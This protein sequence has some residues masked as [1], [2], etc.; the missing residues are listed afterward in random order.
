MEKTVWGGV[1]MSIPKIIHYCW[2]GGKE[3]PDSAIKCIKSWKK[4][5]PDY[6]IRRW[7]EHNF[8]ISTNEFCNQAYQNKALGFAPDYIRLWIIYNYGGIYF[9]TDVQVIKNFDFL[10]SNHG[11]AGFEQGTTNNGTFLVNFG[12]GFAAEPYNPVIKKHL[13]LYDKMNFVLDD[14]SFNRIPSPEYTTKILEEFGLDRKQDCI[15]KLEEF[16][17]YPHEYFCPKSFSDGMIKITK[18]TYS[19]HQFDASWFT[20]EDQKRK[21]ERWK[22]AQNYYH[23]LWPNRVARKILGEEVIKRIKQLMGK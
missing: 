13:E 1:N 19:I 7:D 18:H 2:L 15:Q 6:E 20:P 17:I 23:R 5:C 14:G 8:D 16:T 10:L 4:Y 22:A 3:L 21:N 11:F 12:Q 9:D